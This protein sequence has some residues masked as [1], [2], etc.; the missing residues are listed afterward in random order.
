[1]KKPFLLIASCCLLPTFVFANDGKWFNLM[2]H[3]PGGVSSTSA[4]IEFDSIPD[5]DLYLVP[6]PEP[7]C[8]SQISTGPLETY[9]NLY[10]ISPTS[11]ISKTITSCTWDGGLTAGDHTLK[12]R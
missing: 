11:A 6:D 10:N 3:L 5:S 12:R 2:T 9:I 8:S 7:Y 1:M 4:Q